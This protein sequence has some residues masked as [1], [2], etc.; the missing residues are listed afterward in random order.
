VTEVDPDEDPADVEGRAE[1]L[2]NEQF[3]SANPEAHLVE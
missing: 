2:A 3:R 1:G